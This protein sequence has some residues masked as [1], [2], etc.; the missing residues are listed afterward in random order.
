MSET[1]AGIGTLFLGVGVICLVSAG[2]IHMVSPGYKTLECERKANSANR[3]CHSSLNCDGIYC[4]SL[5][6]GKCAFDMEGYVNDNCEPVT[7]LVKILLIIA[8]ILISLG[9]LILFPM[10]VS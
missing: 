3:T 6:G 7:G 2:L 8:G 9:L 4:K 5:G 10:I 1:A